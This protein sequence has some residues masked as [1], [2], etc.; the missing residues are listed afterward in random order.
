M[1]FFQGAFFNTSQVCIASK[2]IY[3]HSSMYEPFLTALT[4][5]AQS[6]KVG[7]PDEPGVMLG[8]IQNS[9]QYDK[10]KTFFKDTKDHGYRLAL[11]SGD[12]PDTPGYFVHPTIVDNPPDDSLIVRE[13][14][15][16]P[17]VPVQRYDSVDEVVRRANDTRSGLGATVF[18]ADPETLQ[19]VADRLEAGVVWVNSFPRPGPEG[20]FG[21]VK[22]SGIGTEFGTMG[23]LAY[24]NAKSITTYK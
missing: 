19:Q 18:G 14:P 7:T 20:Q 24:A 16:G 3:V 17:I 11:G 12:V 21:G 1:F 22:E 23:I 15:F 5:V 2:R 6:L 9:M 4:N 10:V 13:E 8:P